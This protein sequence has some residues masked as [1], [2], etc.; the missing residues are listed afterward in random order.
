MQT[1]QKGLQFIMDQ[2]GCVL[3]VYRDQTGHP[4]IGIGHLVRPGE[5]F[6]GSITQDQAME[7]LARDVGRFE[8]AVNAYGLDLTQ[9]QFDMLVDFAFNCGEGALGQLLSHGLEDVPNQL[10]KWIHSNGRVVRA[11]VDRR[12]AEVDIWNGAD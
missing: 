9:R 11:L 3:H 8:D 4:T 1:S 2:E 6:V 10:P 7:L 12:A 5:R